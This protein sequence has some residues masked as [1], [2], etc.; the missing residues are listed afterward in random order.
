MANHVKKIFLPISSQPTNRYLKDIMSDL[1]IDKTMTFHR[2][3]HSFRALAAKKGIRDRVAERIMV[4]A[5]S[6]DVKDVYIRLHD[7]DIV[8][9]VRGKWIV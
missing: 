5:E 6:N 3:R 7:E 1:K 4:H 2:A 8:K 9:G